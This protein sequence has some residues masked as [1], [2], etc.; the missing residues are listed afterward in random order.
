M[1]SPDGIT[2]SG[3]MLEIKC[4]TRRA[5]SD[6]PPLHYFHQMLMQL[7]CCQLDECDFFD[8]EFI[9]YMFE[10]EWLNESLTWWNSNDSTDSTDNFSFN[11]FGILLKSK[12]QENTFFY[13][14]PTVRSSQDFLKWAKTESNRLDLKE[15]IETNLVYYKLQSYHIVRIKHSKDFLSRNLDTL[16]SVWN[17]IE[18]YRTP[19]G[20]SDFEELVKG[21]DRDPTVRTPRAKKS[22][23][24]EFSTMVLC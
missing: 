9:E 24:D 2:T 18:H 12:Y 15:E 21:K 6:V 5:V 19:A 13:A 17:R 22:V 20:A 7:E 11:I 10:D 16:T 8:C 4:P 3:R 1:A 14:P 23:T